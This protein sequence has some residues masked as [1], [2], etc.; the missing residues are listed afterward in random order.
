MTVGNVA[1]DIVPELPR[2]VADQAVLVRM[3]FTDADG[4][5]TVAGEVTLTVVAPDGVQYAYTLSGGDL[6]N[7]STGVYE[8]TV[9]LTMA[10]D[11]L[12][13]AQGS[14]L[15]AANQTSVNVEESYASGTPLPP[16]AGGGSEGKIARVTGGVYVPYGGGADEQPLVWRVGTGWVGQALNLAAAAA[17]SGLLAISHIAPGTNG[18]VL[19]TT[20]GVA[21]WGAPT[22]TPGGGTLE[23]QYNNAGVLDGASGIKV[24]GAETALAFGATPAT[25]GL[26]RL[27]HNP[28]V[29][30]LAGRN[31]ANAAD[32]A[33]IQWGAGA[34]DRLTI[35]DTAV[36]SVVL[37]IA[38]GGSYT[39]QINGAAEYTL[40]ATALTM[41][42]NNLLMGAGF[43]SWGT[44]PAST[45]TIRL[46]ASAGAQVVFRNN[47]NSANISGIY[48]G[49]DDVLYIGD[50]TNSVGMNLLVKTGGFFNLYFSATPEYQFSPT[51]A[52]FTDN[53]LLFGTTPATAGV[54]RLSNATDIRARDAGNTTN[55]ILIRSDA[56]DNILVG[57]DAGGNDTFIGVATG[58]TVHLRINAVDKFTL[59]TNKVFLANSSTPPSSDPASGGYIYCDSGALKY[60]GSSGTVTTLGAA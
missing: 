55:L 49:T 48:S 8:R 42:G 56:S 12:F 27:P 38:T 59:D 16:P 2:Y 54:I 52:N 21:T 58:K 14:T 35:G 13:H 19:T 3:T 46:P 50:A 53:S 25:A 47:A 15:V 1:I 30:L 6:T 32:A 60:R 40:D 34:N 28:G 26:V 39:L 41:N 7:P 22:T 57:N 43:A 37:N 17:V 29:A 5:L 33:I 45:G 23:V 18:Q 20:G 31:N 36:A 4:V 44:N 9:T 10:A 11:W 51:T 24:V